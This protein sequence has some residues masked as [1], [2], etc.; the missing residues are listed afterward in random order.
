MSAKSCSN[1]RR[2]TTPRS[3]CCGQI[4]DAL[5]TFD[6]DRSCRAIVVASSGR[7]FCAGAE[8]AN[9]EGGGIGGAG[10]DPMRQFYDQALRLFAARKPIVAAVQ[11][12]AVGAGLGIAVAADFRVAALEARFAANFTALGFHPGF[13]LSVTLPRLIGAQNAALMLMTS[14]RIKAEQALS[15]GLVD[16]IAPPGGLMAAAHRL[17]AD[18]ALNAPLALLATRATLRAG[19]AEAVATALVHEHAEQALLR[20]TA[21]H[22]EGVRAVAER[23]PGHFQGL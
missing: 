4:A 13:G 14:R 15:W 2:P 20:G 19:L 5:E 21:D 12:A 1:I 7:I 18:I 3:A 22:A 9:P 6:R 17:A 11:G 23:R 10:P 16:E 8:L